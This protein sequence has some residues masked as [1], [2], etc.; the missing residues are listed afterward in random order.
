MTH[1]DHIIMNPPYSGNLHLKIL[2]EAM[3]H[4]DDI[5]SLEP[6]LWLTDPLVDYASYCVTFD[7]MRKSVKNRLESVEL[8]E[9]DD[10][11]R[12]F[13]TAG[14][15]GVGIFHF[16]KNSNFDI[17]QYK[18]KD[19]L[20]NKIMKQVVAMKSLRSQFTRRCDDP[21]FVPVRRRTHH[22]L[23]WISDECNAKDG[24]QFKTKLE[25]DNFIKSL[26]LW[27]YK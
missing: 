4:S 22:N 27:I 16:I 17:N 12:L 6:H 15:F 10:F 1:F 2:R 24:I 5:V 13:K 20:V 23:K 7:K 14:E 8:V 26:D 3:Q 21:L 11:N 25:M 18:N 19:P 9:K